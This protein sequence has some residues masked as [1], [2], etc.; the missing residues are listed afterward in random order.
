[1]MPPEICTG[2]CPNFC[3]PFTVM[4]RMPG[5]GWWD[6]RLIRVEAGQPV[7][8]NPHTQCNV[9]WKRACLVVQRGT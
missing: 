9:H 3:P 4:Y 5:P 6:R 1:M 7:L 2:I 8:Q